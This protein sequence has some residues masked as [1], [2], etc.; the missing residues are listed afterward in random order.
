MDVNVGQRLKLLWGR[1]AHDPEAL[2]EVRQIFLA[3]VIVVMVC[4][5]AQTLLIKPRQE[6]LQKKISQQK[7]R[8][9]EAD[10]E[11]WPAPFPKAVISGA[12]SGG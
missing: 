9:N 4:Y 5:A 2:I 10:G 11:A 12:V 6:S 8:E 3:L 1:V 7:D